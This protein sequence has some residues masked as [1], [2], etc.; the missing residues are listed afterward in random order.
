MTAFYDAV[1]VFLA[2]CWYWSGFMLLFVLLLCGAVPCIIFLSHVSVRAKPVAA[3]NP[4]AVPA[5]QQVFPPVGPANAAGV[6]PAALGGNNFDDPGAPFDYVA[7]SRAATQPDELARCEANDGLVAHLS[8]HC[9]AKTRDAT[10]LGLLEAKAAAWKRSTS[11]GNAE[12]NRIYP[13]SVARALAGT[14]NGRRALLSISTNPDTIFEAHAAPSGVGIT[15]PRATWRQVFN[16]E[17]YVWEP[18]TDWWVPRHTYG[19]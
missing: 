19:Q 4:Q 13:G 18:F 9:W 14:E 8:P 16:R 5:N 3:V 15:Y 12:F 7:I 6:V 2:W 11:T 17:R 10:L 1:L